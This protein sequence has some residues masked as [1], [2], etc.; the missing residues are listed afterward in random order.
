MGWKRANVTGKSASD[1]ARMVSCDCKAIVPVFSPPVFT[2]SS[3]H[4][5]TPSFSRARNEADRM[6]FPSLRLVS[7]F[8]FLS[9]SRHSTR[10]HDGWTRINDAHV[11][12]IH[13]QCIF[14]TLRCTLIVGIFYRKFFAFPWRIS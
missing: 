6:I 8:F 5:S 1:V 3:F 7:T 10:F 11:T 12:T 2:R 9:V 13:A 4:P 14:V